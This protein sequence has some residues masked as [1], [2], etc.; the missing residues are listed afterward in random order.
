MGT[1]F[2]IIFTIFVGFVAYKIYRCGLFCEKQPPKLDEE[3]WGPGK[4][5]AKEDTSIRPFTIS[6]SDE[7][8][9]DLEMRLKNT[10]YGH[11]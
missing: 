9:K 1:M 11:F 4:R 3:W 2:T 7:Q 10:R 5:V 8:I 6:V